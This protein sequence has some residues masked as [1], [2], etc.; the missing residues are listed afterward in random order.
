MGSSK[1]PIQPHQ[2]RVYRDEPDRDDAASMSSAVLLGDIDSLPDEDL[3]SYS[4]S[5]PYTDEPSSTP[6]AS[7]LLQPGGRQGHGPS[8]NPY[9]WMSP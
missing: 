9:V 7:T 6:A 8:Y 2:P 1:A 3:P 5:Q 4:D